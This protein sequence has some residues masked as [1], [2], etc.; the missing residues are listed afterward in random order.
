MTSIDGIE[1]FPI[2]S[3]ILFVSLFVLILY[4][5]ITMKNELIGEV[6]GIPIRGTKTK[7]TYIKKC[8]SC[9]KTTL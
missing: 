3:L 1:M 2:V 8:D 5:T 6:S 4:W 7:S 9:A